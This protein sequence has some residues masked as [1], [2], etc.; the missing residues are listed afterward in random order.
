MAAG[1]F[2]SG[3][4]ETA[5]KAAVVELPDGSRKLTITDFETDPGPDLR[6]YLATDEGAGDFE[7]LGALKGNKGDQQYD[8]PKGVDLEKHGTVVI[9]CRAF[10]VSFGH[11]ALE[12]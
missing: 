7:D 4:H 6:I 8:V 1:D 9:W 2:Q 10:S 3:A 11:S 12:S 5:G